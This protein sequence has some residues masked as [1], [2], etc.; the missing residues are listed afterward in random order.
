MKYRITEGQDMIQRIEYFSE[1]WYQ[2]GEEKYPSVTLILNVIAKGYGYDEWLKTAGH[3]ANYIVREAQESGSKLHNSIERLIK[4]EAVS[5]VE[6]TL[7]GN[8]E[9]TKKEWK[10]LNDWLNW[11]V[12]LGIEPI[13]I[14]TMVFSH[15]WKVAGTADFICKIGEDIWLLDWKTGNSIYET[16]NIQVAAY[17]HMWNELNPENKVNRAG[18]VHIGAS[19]RTKKDLNNVGVKLVE[20]NMENDKLVFDNTVD[21]FRRFNP[22]IKAP[23]DEY[24]LVLK[25]DNGTIN[26][27][28]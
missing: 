28:Q 19:N 6:S 20:V 8:N 13:A 21:L 26:N 24:D 12:G 18:V 25:L 16:S 11:Y 4:G 9:F 23:T 27:A 3:E 17:A 22:T 14:E 1:H 7:S 10:K 5:A 2:V 15:V